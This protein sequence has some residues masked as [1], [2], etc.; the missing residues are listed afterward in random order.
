MLYLYEHVLQNNELQTDQGSL[1]MN[2]SYRIMNCKWIKVD[3]IN[4]LY[5]HITASWTVNQGRL[6]LNTNTSYRI[7]SCKQTKI[8]CI[9]MNTSYRIM[10]CSQ[11][12]AG[13]GTCT[14]TE[15]WTVTRNSFKWDWQGCFHCFP[16]QWAG[17]SNSNS[18]T[19]FYNDC[20][21]CSVKTCLTTSPC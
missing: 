3:Y 7:M 1:Y 13:I 4:Y 16:E 11:T 15:R 6:H 2:T 21:L 20:S 12:K 17:N 18:K 8:D 5:E 9:Y 10:N 19:L 14:A